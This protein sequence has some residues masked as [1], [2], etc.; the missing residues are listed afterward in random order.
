M[1][2]YGKLACNKTFSILLHPPYSLTRVLHFSSRFTFPATLTARPKAKI[3]INSIM[4]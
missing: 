4:S 1:R 2:L 3:E